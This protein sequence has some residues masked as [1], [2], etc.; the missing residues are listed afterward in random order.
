[1]GNRHVHFPVPQA[2]AAHMHV[3]SYE[4]VS[5]QSVESARISAVWH[6]PEVL[7]EFGVDLGEVLA[8]A[9]VR[10]DIFS[11]R[12]NLIDYAALARL[13]LE[14]ARQSHCDHIVL[15]I[16]QR[17][18]LA[19]FGLA[20]QAALLGETAGKGLL[21][22]ANHFSRH[23]TATFV[24]LITTGDFAR[25]VYTIAARRMTDTEIL[26]LGGLATAFNVMQD[27]CGRGFLPTVVTFASR[28]PSNLK[29]LHKYFRA[30]LRFD[31]DESALVFERHWLDRPL[32]AV[33]PH[34]R[35]RVEFELRSQRASMLA[36][37]PATVRRILHKQLLVG[38]CSMDRVAALLG[39]H[40]RTL[41]RHLQRHEVSYG[42][43]LDS[44]L[45][46][47]ASQ[48]LRNTDLQVQ[49]VAESLNYSSAANFATAF[50]RWTGSTPSQYRRS[51]LTAQRDGQHH[52]ERARQQKG[53][54]G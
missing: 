20:A 15:L 24:S 50:R 25:F 21:N 12:E 26:H 42:E 51:L 41:D 9:G 35:R 30:P 32:P 43:L 52:E 49:H 1:M 27:L 28:S 44:V 14:C 4:A 48:L 38:Q 47:V 8:A 45:E 7:R 40:R 16:C 53:G 18:R 54:A 46:E 36:D 2:R 29:P 34:A 5:A 39:M 6:L 23:S 13:L 37:F 10:P 19:D 17:T 33:D 3:S 11:D 22:F 31:C